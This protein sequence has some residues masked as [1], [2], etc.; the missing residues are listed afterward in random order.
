VLA[1]SRYYRLPLTLAAAIAA[2]APAGAQAQGKLDA[3]FRV[4]LAG[5]PIG[6]G[7]WTIEMTDTHY[8][9][10]ASGATTGLMKVFTG[11]HG[12]STATGTLAA[13]QPL[14]SIYASTIF[15]RKKSD[16]IRLTIDKGAVKELKLDPPQEADPARVPVTEAHQHGVLDPM[17]ALLLRTPGTGDPVSADACQRTVPIFDGRIRYD[18]Q[19]TFKRMEQV[20]TDKGYSG[21]VVVCTLSFTP[22]AGYAPSRMAIRYI[23]ERRDMEVWL[24]P[25]AGTRVLVPYRAESPTPIGP[26][27]FEAT[28]FVSTPA[29]IRASANGSKA[30]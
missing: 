14:S 2:T 30:Q 6:K 18:L 4:T 15:S 25:V 11:G 19:L 28:Q 17:T 21:P 26:V 29:P 12:V 16:A 22:V 27:V 13:G 7:T 3:A 10:A 23:S 1:I 5:I 8:T 20:K 24:A 9:A